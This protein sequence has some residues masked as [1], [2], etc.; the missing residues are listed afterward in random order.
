M[1]HVPEEL[2]ES[3][4]QAVGAS[5]GEKLLKLQKTHRKAQHAL[6][7]F[8]YGNFTS[9]HEDSAGVAIYVYHVVLEAFARALPRPRR[10]SRAQI[11]RSFANQRQSK[12]F[13]FETSLDESPEPHALRYV[14]EALSEDA[15]DVVLSEQE[16]E[17]IFGIM[18]TAILCLHH[19]CER[20]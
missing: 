6:T 16:R 2:I 14:Y 17:H 11:E 18:E 8:A 12:E 13:D 9:L 3:T 7:M 4:W 5:T 20:K 19:S 10:V 15:D 1:I